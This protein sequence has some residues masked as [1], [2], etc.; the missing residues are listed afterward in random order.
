MKITQNIL[1]EL[2][3]LEFNNGSVRI[4]RPLDRKTYVELNKVLEACGGKWNRSAKLHLFPGDAAEALD[5]VISTG[6]VKTASEMNFFPTSASDAEDLVAWAFERLVPG[7]VA[8]LEPSAGKGAIVKV[9]MHKGPV[10]AVEVDN[11]HKKDLESLGA[12][13][14]VQIKS[15]FDKIVTPT[16]SHVIGNPPFAKVE[17]HDCIDHFRQSFGF[18][19]TGG[20]QVKIMPKSIEW[21]EDMRHKAFRAFLSDMNA[22][23]EPMAPGSF[24]HAKTDVETVR[25]RVYK[26]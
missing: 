17:G 26:S 10:D 25:V 20:C 2:A 1:A 9:A 19:R 22:D 24:K 18:L 8:I 6:E 7:P 14:V 5:G 23:I 21:R 3:Q 15:I 16:Y 13:V 12:G 4:V 11:R